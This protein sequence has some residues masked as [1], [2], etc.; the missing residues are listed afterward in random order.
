[1]SEIA[2][3]AHPLG[4]CLPVAFLNIT[5]HTSPPS[6]HPRHHPP[7]LSPSSRESATVNSQHIRPPNPSMKP[8]TETI[9][10]TKNKST[11]SSADG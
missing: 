9:S 4:H 10:E 3:L 5:N 2:R 6:T 8:V 7:S 11:H 1:M